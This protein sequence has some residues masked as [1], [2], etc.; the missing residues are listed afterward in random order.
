LSKI[1]NSFTSLAVF[2]ACL[3]LFGLAAYTNEQRTREISIRKVLGASIGSLLSLLYQ[4]YFRLIIVSFVIASLVAY[5]FAQEWLSNFVYRTQIDYQ[6]FVFALLGTVLI[7]GVT[8]M[9]QSLK[10]VLRNPV[11]TLKSE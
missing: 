4:S 3:G 5:L 8:V 10:T 9:Y 6:P 11:D 1:F 2:I 7:A